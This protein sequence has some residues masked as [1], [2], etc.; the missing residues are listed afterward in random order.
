[1]DMELYELPTDIVSNLDTKLMSNFW[2]VLMDLVGVK[3]NLCI[4]FHP[5]TN[6]QI[7]RLKQKI[8]QYLRYYCLCKQDD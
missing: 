7:E 3:L 5:E 6:G 2:Q 1:M 4:V 8:K